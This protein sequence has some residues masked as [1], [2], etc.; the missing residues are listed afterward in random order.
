MEQARR[1]LKRVFGYDTFLPLQADIIANIL[2]RRDTLA[3]MPTGSGKSLC[4]QLPALLFDGLTV[5][6][7]PL[8]ALMQD[9]VAQLRELDIPAVFLNST[10]NYHSY[11]TVAR[12]VKEGEIKL[13]YIAPETLQRPETL[14]MLDQCNVDCL[15]ID[16]AHCISSWGHDFRPS[17]RQLLPVRDRFPHAVCVALTATATPR[18]QADIKMILGFDEANEFIASFNRDNLYLAVQPRTEGLAQT[19][20]FLEAHR[21]QSGIIYCGTR[22]RVDILTEQLLAHGYTALPY[23]A[24]LKDDARRHHQARFIRDEVPIMV[25]TVAFGL[26]INKSNVRFVLH[27]NLPKNIESYYQQIGR[28]GRD[29]L[30][31]DCLLLFSHSDVYKTRHLIE[32]APSSVRP[33][34]EARLQALVR[35]AH[36]TMCRRMPLLAYFGEQAAFDSCS[37]CD[38]CLSEGE[39]REERDVTIPALK[40]LSCVKRTGEIFGVSHIVKV[41]RGSRARSVLSRKHDRLSTY[42]IGMEYSTKEWKQLAQRFIEQDLVKQDMQFGGLSLTPRAYK[43][44]KGEKVYATLGRWHE[45]IGAGVK[46]AYDHGLFV[47]LRALRK[48]LADKANVPA[49]VVFSDRSLA[50]M[51]TYYPQTIERLL[52]IHGVGQAKLEKY[53]DAFLS[54]IR[55]YCE[56][57]GIQERVRPPSTPLPAASGERRFEEVGEL[58]AAGRTIEQLQ[59]LYGVKQQTIVTHLYRYRQL[60]YEVEAERVRAAS[61]LSIEDQERVLATI[62]ELGHERLRAIYEA[63]DESIPYDELHIMRLC[64][65]CRTDG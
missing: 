12:R 13:L 21:D 45:Q 64:Y 18:V 14:V 48:R 37:L 57:H 55:L 15:T 40:F 2:Q 4:Y 49:Y 1:L 29:G 51:A 38:N 50:E 65:L 36:T 16:E 11:V 6:V 42:G 26:G 63:L 20:A 31:A 46:P 61:A 5:V 53:A 28:A 30:Q 39:E 35:Y 60:G 25:A 17:Y 32:K 22:R 54:L 7:S 10:L 41:L 44:F 59:A 43:V 8:I 23:H 47:E 3:I 19:L 56:E 9:Q 52:T 24:G 62:G 58:F 34:K 33:G 27:Y